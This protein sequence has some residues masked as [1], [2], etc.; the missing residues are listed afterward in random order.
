MKPQSVLVCGSSASLSGATELP[1]AVRSAKALPEFKTNWVFVAVLLIIAAAG[2]AFSQNYSIDWCKISG[3]GG[4]S[5]GAV[6]AISGTI[7][8]HDA[9]GPLTGGQYSVIGGFWVLPVA[10]QI[11]NAPTLSIAWAEHG[12]VRISWVPATPGFSLESSA[13][14]SPANWG[15]APS[16]TN[17]PAVVPASEAARFYRLKKP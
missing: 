11:T 10:V 12:K 6:Y 9:G 16:G 17:N 3:G 2:S 5:T 7:G 8:Q 13:S 14:A 1:Y 4:T 15:P